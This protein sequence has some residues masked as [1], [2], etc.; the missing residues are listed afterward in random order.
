MSGFQFPEMIPDQDIKYEQAVQLLEE[1]T[2]AQEEGLTRL[3]EVEREKVTYILKHL[4]DETHVAGESVEQ[5]LGTIEKYRLLLELKQRQTKKLTG[6]PTPASFSPPPVRY[7]LPEI[8]MRSQQA[9]SNSNEPIRAG[10]GTTPGGFSIPRPMAAVSPLTATSPFTIPMTVPPM[11]TNSCASPSS[12]AAAAR[13]CIRQPGLAGTA[14]GAITNPEDPFYG[15]TAV[16]RAFITCSNVGDQM[17]RYTVD[18]ENGGI[19]FYVTGRH[20]KTTRPDDCRN[21]LV[22]SGEGTVRMQR[23]NQPD[24]AGKAA[25]SLAVQNTNRGLEFRMQ[26]A[27]PDTCP[28]HDSGTVIAK[29][30]QSDMCLRTG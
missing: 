24:C 22:I 16:L 19:R 18:G 11:A 2:A 12:S 21:G 5:L 26:I 15:K 28:A 20:I 1:S 29:Y 17:L 4:G 30:A 23:Q 25:F 10:Q 14:R 27:A 3:T 8:N 9:K 7:A 6:F 13:P